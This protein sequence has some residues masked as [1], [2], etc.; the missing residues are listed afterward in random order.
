VSAYM[1]KTSLMLQ[2]PEH[3]IPM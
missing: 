2:L 1:K 3:I